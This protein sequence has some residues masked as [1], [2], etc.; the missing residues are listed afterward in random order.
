MSKVIF[1]AM[2]TL[3][4][5]KS[6]LKAY[7]RQLADDRSFPP[8]GIQ[9]ALHTAS[10]V[11]GYA[12]AHEMIHDIKSKASPEPK[13]DPVQAVAVTVTTLETDHST[14]DFSKTKVFRGWGAATE[15][16]QDLVKEKVEAN[17]CSMDEVLEFCAIE[18]PDDAGEMDEDEVLEWVVSNNGIF[19]LMALVTYLD[20][21]LT[22]VTT[23]EDWI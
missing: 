3:G 8:L 11:H 18:S 15:F 23:D 2:N 9:K 13:D 10:T 17:D 5:F 7:H 20:Y 12:N 1:D 19:S 4:G 14:V 21:S 6:F 16:V 22:T